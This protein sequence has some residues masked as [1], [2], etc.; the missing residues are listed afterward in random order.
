[1]LYPVQDAPDHIL[2][3]PDG[4]T[5]VCQLNPNLA[6]YNGTPLEEQKIWRIKQISRTTDSAG[7]THTIIK[8]PEG[9]AQGFCFA[10]SAI[11]SYTFK[12]HV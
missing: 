9:D 7:N 8:Y 10:I 11:S 1:M 6:D 12:Y 2:E 5:Y 4:T 3:T